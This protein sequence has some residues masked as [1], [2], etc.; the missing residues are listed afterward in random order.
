MRE[1]ACHSGHL[2]VYIYSSLLYCLT[3]L[4]FLCTGDDYM[5]VRWLLCCKTTQYTSPIEPSSPPMIWALPPVV[6]APL[7]PNRAPVPSCILNL[8]ASATFD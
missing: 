5:L 3:Q 7:H 6:G 4:C 8:I 1:G 2:A